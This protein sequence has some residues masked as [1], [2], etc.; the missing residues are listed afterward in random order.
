MLFARCCKLEIFCSETKTG[1]K[2]LF[3]PEALLFHPQGNGAD[4]GFAA[5]FS[6][7]PKTFT[8]IVGFKMISK[9]VLIM[10]FSD[11]IRSAES[12]IL[13]LQLLEVGLHIA[14]LR[15]Q[16]SNLLPLLLH[17]ALNN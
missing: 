9:T 17:G 14:Q 12:I 5:I 2:E 13:T 15:V 6:V 7:A 11:L 8:L 16:V 10:I 4:F 3:L 1:W